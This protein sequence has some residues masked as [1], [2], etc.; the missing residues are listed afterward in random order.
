MDRRKGVLELLEAVDRLTRSGRP[1]R[2]VISGI[3]PDVEAVRDCVA[4]LG[5]GAVVEL[6]GVAGYDEAPAVYRTGDVFV[7][8]TWSEGFS[9]TILEAMAAGLPIVSTRAVGVIDCLRHED[10]ALLVEPHDVEQ[11]AAAIGRLLDDASLRSRLAE[12]ALA[13]VRTTYS[14]EA[15]SAQIVDVYRSLLG[16]PPDDDWPELEALGAPIDQRC[17]FRAAP[18]LL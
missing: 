18:H 8:P 16:T 1:L 11:L 13:E 5:L 9:N 15:V 12:R 7:S 2:V 10:N 3:G 6:T 17:R 4:Q 14:W